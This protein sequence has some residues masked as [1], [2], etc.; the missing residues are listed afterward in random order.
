MVEGMT[1]RQSPQ[2]RV[3]ERGEGKLERKIIQGQL[4]GTAGVSKL[5]QEDASRT[6]DI[7]PKLTT[8]TTGHGACCGTKQSITLL[9]ESSYA[10]FGW[11]RAR[12]TRGG[13]AFGL[14]ESELQEAR[15]PVIRASTS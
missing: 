8:A 10:G 14:V 4:S 3:A 7:V 9:E 1:A 11:L 6:R 13:P 12:E 5:W 2:R 15:R